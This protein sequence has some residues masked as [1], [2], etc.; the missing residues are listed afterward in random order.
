MSSLTQL[1][2]DLP[3]PQ[4]DGGSDHL[5]GSRMPPVTLTA[6]SGATVDVSAIAGW[7]VYY[8]YP[9]TGRPDVALPD[10]WEQIPGAR[11]CTPQSCAFRDHYAELTAL[12]AQVFG[13]STQSTAYQLEAVERLH[14]PYAMLSDEN[15][16]L[17]QAMQLPLM[18]VAGMR[19]IKRLTLIVHDGII[20]KVFYPVFPPDQN[21]ADVIEWLRAN[22]S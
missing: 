22:G 20:R 4:D 16:D 6:T 15:F 7:V 11:G 5:L 3:I 10:N 19:L 18:E 12:H 8:C 13:I 1:P 9:M 14:L 2:Q 21:A 17:T